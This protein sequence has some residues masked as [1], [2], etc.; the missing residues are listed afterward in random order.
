MRLVHEAL[1]QLGP[2]AELELEEAGAGE[3]LLGRAADAVVQRRR[4]RV[5][6]R[7]DEEV[8]R[9]REPRPER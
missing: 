3:R 6:D 8:G 5:L 1:E 2:I 9:G 4:A 7:A